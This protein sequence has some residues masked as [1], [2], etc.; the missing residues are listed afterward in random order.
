[1]MMQAPLQPSMT[2]MPMMQTVP[3]A[4]LPST[5]ASCQAAPMAPSFSMPPP[6][7]STL[8]PEQREFM[9]MVRARQMELPPDMRQ[10]VQKL[11]KKEGAKATK[12]LHSAVRN[13]GVARSELEEALQARSNLI[14]SWKT[15]LTDSIKTW[16]EYTALFQNQERDLQERIQKAQENF[17]QAKTLA[18]HSQEEAGKIPTIEIKDDEEE[19]TGEQANV[20]HSSGQIHAGLMNLSASLQQL[21]DQADAIEIEENATKRARTESL[22]PNMVDVTDKQAE[23]GSKRSFA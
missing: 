5:S 9:E 17:V 12:D 16:Q 20:D 15:F 21:R 13:L 7:Q 6:P 19:L 3:I 22:D 23:P 2:Q 11:V 14:A 18:A 10:K 1:M 4:S 8:D